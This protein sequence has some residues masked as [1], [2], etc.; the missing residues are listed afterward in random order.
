MCFNAGMICKSLLKHHFQF[1][2]VTNPIQKLS[3][4]HKVKFKVGES[5]TWGDGDEER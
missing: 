1:K 2:R 5:D 4:C 3:E